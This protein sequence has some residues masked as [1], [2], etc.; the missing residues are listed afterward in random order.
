MIGDVLASSIICNNLKQNNP[1]SQI[2]YLI[3][4][5]TNPV[6][7]N[8]PNIDSI[9]HFDPIFRKNKLKFLQFLIAIRNRKY[10]IVID[11]YGKLESNLI[12]AF[13]G[14]HQKI[15]FHKS[16]TNFLYTTTVN[17]I[18]KPT[19]NAGTA[20]ENRLNLLNPLGLKINLN[21]K[22]QIFLTETEIQNGKRILEEYHV[23]FSKKIFM[24]GVLGS[25]SKKT[26]PFKFMAKILDSIV[27][28]TDATL[29]FNYM[30]SQEKEARAIY[31]LCQIQTQKNINID[32]IPGSIREFLSITH[33]C[34]ALIGNEGGAVNM[35]KALNK[36]TFTIFSTWII[37]EA[38]NSFEDGTTNVSVHL[39]DFKPSL[40]GTKTAKEMKDSA[41][42]LYQEFEPELFIAQLKSFLK[43]N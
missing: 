30:K 37:K 5:F 20:L 3:Y 9:I 27:E 12:V 25:E 34:N 24:I 35:A 18:S 13:S 1:E 16:Y 21:P 33:H 7:E 11:A 17:E 8:N 26:Y 23:D 28:E 42:S 36:S 14:A 22:P 4:P 2:D 32:L 15:G 29:L 39:K 41:L 10:D 31:N 40:Y 38:W 6:I 19:T 43:I